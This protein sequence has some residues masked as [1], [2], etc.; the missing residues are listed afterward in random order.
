MTPARIRQLSMANKLG[1][2]SWALVYWPLFRFSPIPFHAWRRMLLRLFGASIGARARIYPSARIWAPW[3]LR[4]GQDSC[5]GWDVDCYCVDRVTVADR[6]VVS[7]RAYLCTASHDYDSAGHELIT[8]PITLEADAWVAAE[9]FVAPGVTLGTGSVA[10]A[11][12]VV[13]R[14]VAAWT[15]AGGHPATPLKQRAR[16]R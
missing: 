2:L 5:L 4:M 9:A 8:A 3:N 10:L 15:V 12:A 16:L 1:R 6:A 11:R 13:T 14:D 7:Q